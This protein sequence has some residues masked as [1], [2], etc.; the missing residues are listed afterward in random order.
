LA[1]TIG[2]GGRDEA[3]ELLDH[4]AVGLGHA[5]LVEAVENQH[6]AAPG[7]QVQEDGRVAALAGAGVPV[8]VEDVGEAGLGGPVAQVDQQRE[9]GAALFVDRQLGQLVGEAA[10]EGG[11]AGAVVA[12]QHPQP[13]AVALG[14]AQGI[15][16]EILGF[17]GLEFGRDL[18]VHV[19]G[20]EGLLANSETRRLR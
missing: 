16:Q 19:A 14:P 2:G 15:G 4:V 7:E 5:H 17:V 18:L 10:G 3:A 8:V 9:R 6:E 13:A 20:G 11:L 12:Q 1:V